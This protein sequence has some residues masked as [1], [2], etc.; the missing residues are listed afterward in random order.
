MDAPACCCPGHSHWRRFLLLSPLLAAG[1]SGRIGLKGAP[2][3]Q[4]GTPRC[5]NSS[6]TP[7]ISCAQAQVGDIGLMGAPAKL[8]GKAVEG[9]K[10]FLGG[11]IGEN[12]EVGGLPLGCPA[13]HGRQSCCGR[14]RY[15]PSKPA[16]GASHAAGSLT[17]VISTFFPFAAGQGV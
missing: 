9:V 2:A 12:P 16:P 14:A 7:R 6:S 10:I 3:N 5:F 1:A 11:K 17:H 15:D 13:G 8:D 4:D